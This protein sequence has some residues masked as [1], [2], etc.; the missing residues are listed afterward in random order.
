MN[1]M[2]SHSS[3]PKVAY[4]CNAVCLRSRQVYGSNRRRNIGSVELADRKF[5]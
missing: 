4:A 2:S 5:E 3:A 1:T